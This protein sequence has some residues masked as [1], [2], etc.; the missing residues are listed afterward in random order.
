MWE[1]IFE[2]AIIGLH[3]YLIITL[4]LRNLKDICIQSNASTIIYVPDEKDFEN[5]FF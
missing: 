1:M 3:Y 4:P 2:V 5:T